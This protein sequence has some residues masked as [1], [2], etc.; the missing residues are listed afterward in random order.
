[1]NNYTDPPTPHIEA[2]LLTL[3]PPLHS[4][5]RIPKKP[6]L[7]ISDILENS[8]IEFYKD[9]MRFIFRVGAEVS[10]EALKEAEKPEE[11]IL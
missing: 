1:M 9:P 3:T 2:T 6:L 4:G 10:L 11:K 5:P 8:D 7:G